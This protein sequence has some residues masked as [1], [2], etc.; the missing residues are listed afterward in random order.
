MD[1]GSTDDTWRVARRYGRGVQVLRQPRS[2]SGRARNRGLEATSG[3]RVAFLDAD[4]VWVAEK[5]RLQLPVLDRDPR[6][7]LVFSDRG[8]S[9]NVLRTCYAN[10]DTAIVNDIPSEARLHPNK[11]GILRVE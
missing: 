10:R 4:D 8:G 9:R 1:D 3:D 7:G 6:L 11:W 2:G 5:S